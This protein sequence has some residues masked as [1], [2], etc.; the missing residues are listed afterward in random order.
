MKRFLIVLILLISVQL[1][2]LANEIFLEAESFQNKGGWVVDQQFMDLM[3]S[4]YLMAHGMGVPV[5]DAETTAEFPSTGEYNIFVRTFNWTSPWHDDEGPGKF[6]IM[7]NGQKTGAVLGAEGSEWLWQ[8]AGKV[9]ISDKRVKIGLH[10]LTGFN[11][12]VDAIYFTKDNTP[13]PS[14]VQA[15]GKFRKKQ[16]GIPVKPGKAAKFDLV[17]AGGGVAGTAAAI[18]A[19]RLGLKVALIQDR[20]VLG[21]NNSSEVR[22]HLGGKNQCGTLSGTW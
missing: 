17:V 11:G 12:R 3:G 1:Q 18:S 22:V 14:E 15:L 6:N 19:A 10:D 20:P 13:P 9:N 16:L 4:S 21:G 2:T 7:V 5:A 8:N